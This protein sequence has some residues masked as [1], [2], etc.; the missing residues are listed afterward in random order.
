[1]FLVTIKLNPFGI[2]ET[3]SSSFVKKLFNET[4]PLIATRALNR[5][6]LWMVR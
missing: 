5:F 2:L 1:M 6:D 4:A 3:V